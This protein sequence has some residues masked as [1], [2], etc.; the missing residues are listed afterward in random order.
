MRP[1]TLLSATPLLRK[2]RPIALGVL[3]AVFAL[4]CFSLSRALF[5]FREISMNV[6]FWSLFAALCIL[7][8][9][10]GLA[11]WR[12]RL[13]PHVLGCIF[14][15]S[16]GALALFQTVYSFDGPR[17]GFVFSTMGLLRTGLVTFAGLAAVLRVRARLRESSAPN[18][19]DA[20]IQG[21]PAGKLPARDGSSL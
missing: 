11:I 13:W 1:P 9:A 7:V 8:W 17:V 20:P 21:T 3:W 12:L 18:E 10:V 16:Q 4:Y 5:G 2:E 14:W 15:V 6:L 19:L